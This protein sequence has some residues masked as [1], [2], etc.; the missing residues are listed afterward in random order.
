MTSLVSIVGN[1]MNEYGFTCAVGLFVVIA[2]INIIK[3]YSRN[4]KTNESI[5][6]Q[7]LEAKSTHE[8]MEGVLKTHQFIVKDTSM[9]NYSFTAENS[10]GIANLVRKNLKLVYTHV[11]T[12][13]IDAQDPHANFTE[14]TIAISTVCQVFIV[15][16]LDTT[17]AS[18]ED[19]KKAFIEKWK[20]RIRSF[21]PLHRM[22]FCSSEDGR[23]AAV[24]QL[25]PVLSVEF[26]PEVANRI[27][28][29]VNQVVIVS[30]Q[31][32]AVPVNV[33]L[34]KDYVEVLSIS[35]LL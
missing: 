7:R 15:V 26:S 5:S 34:V 2:T 28:P 11:V 3:F 16:H 31:P 18:L 21:L 10:I 12:L 32:I 19:A 4:K 14:C 13:A 20:D 6:L 35:R 25:R 29:H 9:K 33:L 27:E 24:R 8:F 23:V 30:K 22:L 1:L 17:V